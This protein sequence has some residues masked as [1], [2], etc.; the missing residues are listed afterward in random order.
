[1]A[2]PPP[3]LRRRSRRKPLPSPWLQ[4][5]RWSRCSH[6]AQALAPHRRKIRGGVFCQQDQGWRS[7]KK[8]NI[9]RGGHFF[10]R[11]LFFGAEKEVV[12]VFTDE[13]L[14]ANHVEIQ[15]MGRI[16]EGNRQFHHLESRRCCRFLLA[17]TTGVMTLGKFPSETLSNGFMPKKRAQKPAGCCRCTESP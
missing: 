8:T 6:S 13:S 12:F 16:L 14:Q 1:M 7:L 11:Y 15:F 10:S 17:E 9:T 4:S 3:R 2:S 5:S